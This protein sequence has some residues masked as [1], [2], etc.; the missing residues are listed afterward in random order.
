MAEAKKSLT[1]IYDLR[2]L[3]G[4][5]VIKN[6][7]N[8]NTALAENIKLKAAASKNVSSAADI[9]EAEKYKQKIK[10]LTIEELKLRAAQKEAT[11]EKKALAVAN[12]QAA[13]AAKIE[14]QNLVA[15]EGSYKAVVNQM[16]ILRPLVQNANASSTINFGG[17]ELNFS[18]AIAEFKK[19]SAAEQDFRRQFQ[20]DG[21]LVGEYTTGIVQAFQ[22]SGLDDLIKN[23]L[24]KTKTEL[25]SLDENFDLLRQELSQIGVTGKGNFE[26]LEK[27]MIENRN[28]ANRLRA[29]MAGIEAQMAKTG[30]IGRQMS[31]TLTKGFADIRSSIGSMILGYVGFQ[32]A[33]SQGSQLVTGAKNISDQITELEVNMGKAEGGADSLV[34]SLKKIDTRTALKGLLEISDVALKAGVSNENLLGVT[35][36]I[37][38]VKVAF[39]KDFGSI[40]Q[41]TET[42]AK[43]I[44]IFFDDG[45]ITEERMLQIGNSIRALANETVASVPFITDFNGR[46]AGLKQVFSNFQLSESIGLAAG[47][48]EFKQ[49]AETTSTVLV[50]VLPKLAT[51]TEKYGAIVGMTAQQFGELINNNPVEALIKVSEALVKNGQGVEEISAALADSE[52]GSGRITT[53]LATLGGKA[54]IFRDRIARAGETIKSTDAITGAFA[55]KNDNLAAALDKISKKFTD[56]AGNKN[57]QGTLEVLGLL[58]AN[59]AGLLLSMPWPIFLTSMLLAIGYTNTW[60]GAK[61]RLVAVFALEKGAM[62]IEAAQMTINNGIRAASNLIIAASTAIMAK[63]TFATGLAAI[64]WRALG[65]AIRVA[66]GPF[67]IALGVFTALI[68]VVGV[69]SARAENLSRTMRDFALQSQF[70]NETMREARLEISAQVNE[71]RTLAA[72]T[73]DL[74]LGTGS[75]EAALK[76]LIAISPEYL[77]RLTLE[78]TATDEG[79]A[80]IERYNKA[81]EGQA[82][83]KAANA[84]TGR[85]T[86]ERERLEIIKQELELYRNAPPEV[87]RTQFRQLSDDA[88]EALQGGSG[89][90]PE[91]IVI[92]RLNQQ[93][94]EKNK[95]IE[96]ATQNVLTQE[97]NASAVRRNFLYNEIVAAQKAMNA[98]EDKTSQQFLD[99][100]ARLRELSGKYEKEFSEKKE[101]TSGST[102]AG[103]IL[104]AVEI[105]IEKMQAAI[106]A[107]DEQIKT[108]KGSQADLDKLIA[109]RAKKQAELDAALNKQ[110]G[111]K[112]GGGATKSA[113]DILKDSYEAEKKILETQFN[114]KLINEQDYNNRL[115]VLATDYRTKKLSAIRA[116]NKEEQQQQV[117]FNADLAKDQADANQKLF[118][119]QSRFIDRKRD[120]D[121]QAAQEQLDATED[122]PRVTDVAKLQAKLNFYNATLSSQRNHDRAMI[123]LEAKFGVDSEE[124]AAK[125]RDALAE[126]ERQIKKTAY[127]LALES[128]KERLQLAE[129]AGTRQQNE[130]QT[131]TAEKTIKIIEDTDLSPLQ[132]ANKLKELELQQTK[133]L[134]AQE[135]AA[136]RIALQEKE[137]ALLEGLATETEVSEAKKKLKQSEVSFAQFAAESEMSV[138][139]QMTAGLKNALG[140]ITGF[141]KGIK[142]TKDE[143]QSSIEA[144]KQ[145][146]ADA[147]NSAIQNS[148]E[149]Q[150]ARVDQEKQQAFDLINLQQQQAESVAQSEAEKES[151]RK[152]FDKKREEAE[153]KAGEEKKKIALK[154][155]TIDFALAV[156]KTLAAYPFPFSLIPVAALTGAYFLQR[157]QIQAQKFEHGG[158]IPKKTGGPIRGRSHR[159]GGVKFNYEAEDGE[160]AIINKRSAA[161]Q[162]RLT[163][164]GTPR[165]IASAI[166]QVGGGVAF[167]S[168]AR[169]RKF[170]LGGTL[171]ANLK[172]PVGFRSGPSDG[173][174]FSEIKNG[175]MDLQRN[176]FALQGGLASVS[177]QTNER[178]DKIQVV[179][180]AK[181]I[182]D[183][184]TDTKKAKAVARL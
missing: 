118:E 177:N 129:D 6:I 98:I 160:L 181:E 21:T 94:Q 132:K 154:Q 100:Q 84:I 61:L 108:F 164:T 179:A 3:G 146:A 39:G 121:I 63:S 148:F 71:V 72:V 35:K 4:D 1:R 112:K 110:K 147:I 137:K 144:A 143:I 13:N 151:I 85:L 163:V 28:E 88:K 155:A 117:D 79:R 161:S 96:A 33:L 26:A 37:D 171:G 178:I 78:N 184:D 175:M 107:L 165:Q 131:V 24:T 47:F 50:K 122:D 29:S 87:K 54:D 142:A 93:I 176:M 111:S 138:I 183:K 82:R 32:A 116:K 23:Q 90:N 60:M 89:P 105:D 68:T 149:S 18:Q 120:L 152:Q 158:T 59:V 140:N 2:V 109:E 170:E 27:E 104:K 141:F 19:L 57:F 86:E 150:K 75:R 5:T 136:A 103:V 11:N 67:G 17:K 49:S 168:G 9:A 16:K 156:V 173:F 46:M 182:V 64:G 38:Q 31:A 56:I 169:N 159:D 77:N 130:T 114:D 15:L 92:N 20:K 167:A 106:S 99:A 101:T 162:K 80:I 97:R 74:A 34:E 55:R 25:R 125:R 14:Q 65:I 66:M 113:T 7:R 48:E 51:D 123:Q 124:A 95:A 12:T 10:E 139:Q 180:V 81:L 127:D 134:L 69:F 133:N 157:S 73:S 174:D 115:L 128:Y 119:M 91:L 153:K 83:I 53:V 58:I 52:L 70:A 166:N 172:A 36:A 43:L 40:E 22:Q 62:I 8:I 76:K 102:A 42:F 30:G 135:V 41:G 45:E 126:I 145:I 44:N